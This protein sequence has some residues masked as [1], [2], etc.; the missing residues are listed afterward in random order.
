MLATGTGRFLWMLVGLIVIV[1]LMSFTVRS[2]DKRRS[3][4]AQERVEDAQASAATNSAA[5]AIGTVSRSGEATAASE[6]MTRDNE[7]NIR[8]AQG[9][10]DAVNPAVRDAGRNALCLRDAYRNHPD[11]KLHQ[12]TPR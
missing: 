3:Q 10:N 8:N 5:D 2:C 1:G 11:C 12:P 7:R 4:A 9:A 6:Q